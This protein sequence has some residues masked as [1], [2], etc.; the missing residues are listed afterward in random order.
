MCEWAELFRRQE[1]EDKTE[2][3]HNGR[4]EVV[5]QNQEL[6]LGRTMKKIRISN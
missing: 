6:F 4:S 1:K 5:E 3:V 2:S